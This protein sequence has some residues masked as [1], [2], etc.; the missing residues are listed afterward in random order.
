MRYLAILALLLTAAAPPPSLMT[1]PN[2]IRFVVRCVEQNAAGKRTLYEADVDGPPGTDFTVRLRDHGF[3]LDAMFV[4]E[5][6]TSGKLDVRSSLTTRRRHGTSRAGL[7]LWEEDAQEHRFVVGFDQEI[8]LLPFGG[9][10]RAGLLKFD[11]VPE[12]SAG[13]GPMRIRIDDVHSNGAITVDAFRQPHWYAVE[14]E[15]DD[16]PAV[17]SRVSGRIFAGTA[18]SL[19][20]PALGNLMI[21]AR[22]FEHA[23]PW[24][25]TD[26]TLGGRLFAR[27]SRGVICRGEWQSFPIDAKRTLRIRVAPEETG[28]GKGECS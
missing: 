10:G 23:D 12:R 25:Y 2:R 4:S 11:I 22:T 15:I 13:T 14:A 20:L 5:L 17:I 1:T 27:P 24:H 9:A 26:I 18:G 16:G 19:A 7:A 3:T 8:E 6:T 21:T 28:P